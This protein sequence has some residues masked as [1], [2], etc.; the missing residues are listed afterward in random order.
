MLPEN[1]WVAGGEVVLSTDPDLPV[2]TPVKAGETLTLGARSVVVL[3]S[4]REQALGWTT[5]ARRHPSGVLL[6]VQLAR[7]PASTRSCDDEPLGPDRCSDCSACVG[8]RPVPWRRCAGRR[9]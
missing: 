6:G 3:R 9:P 4:D 5:P 8:A 2:G 7:D 1:D